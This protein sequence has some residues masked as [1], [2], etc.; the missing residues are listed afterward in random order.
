[1]VKTKLF[2]SVWN[3]TAKNELTVL[4][5]HSIKLHSI[6]LQNVKKDYFL[7]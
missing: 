4:F 7:I 1:M 6:K 2:F 3:I 5:I